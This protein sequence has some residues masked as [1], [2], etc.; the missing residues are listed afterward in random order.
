MKPVQQT[1]F[2][3][4]E[5]P[6]EEQGNCL[7]ACVASIFEVPIK[8]VPEFLDKNWLSV[9]TKWCRERDTT[10][11]YFSP[12]TKDVLFPETY[13]I[14]GVKSRTLPNPNNGHAVVAWGR[15]VVHDPHPKIPRGDWNDY[16]AEDATMFL[17]YWPE[18]TP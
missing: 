10:P 7:A 4:S 15:K 14:L 8:Q 13:Y 3:G 12:V 11:L 6:S 1:R 9:L 17:R 18:A 5:R 16:E 2:G